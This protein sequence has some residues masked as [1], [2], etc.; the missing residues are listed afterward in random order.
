MNRQRELKTQGV[1]LKKTPFQEASYIMEIFTRD[2]GIVKIIAKG[3]RSQKSK[4]IGLY[5][6]MNEVDLVLYHKPG[7]EWYSVNSINLIEAHLFSCPFDTGLLI[8]AAGEI[9]RQ[10][11]L[12]E[13]ES[14][15]IYKLL[16]T[17]LQYIKLVKKNGIAIFWRFLSRLLKMLGLE[18]DFEDCV[19]CHHPTNDYS[20]F[21]PVRHGFICHSCYRPAMTG[22]L[23]R[24][25][26]E[27]TYL[28]KNLS[29]I[30]NILEKIDLSKS[31]IE[32]MNKIFLVYLS[33][34]YHKKFYLNS[35]EMYE[36]E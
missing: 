36:N 25:S 34:Q 1:I 14:P 9:Y 19:I 26:A 7:S 33:D 28:L 24:N 32:Q 3:V 21:S 2:L 27:V 16:I 29:H 30:G 22:L 12:T 6:S 23:L 5:E 4:T 10:L 35:M 31:T 15:S 17:Y 8:Q 18:T 20:V 13:E 11:V